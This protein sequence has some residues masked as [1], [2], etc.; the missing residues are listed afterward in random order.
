MGPDGLRTIIRN[1]K[2]RVEVTNG[3]IIVIWK[4]HRR[5]HSMKKATIVL[6]SI[7]NKIDILSDTRQNFNIITVYKNLFF[8]LK[9]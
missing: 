8:I 4:N 6:E 3:N 1:L 9:I 2:G 7:G 5:W